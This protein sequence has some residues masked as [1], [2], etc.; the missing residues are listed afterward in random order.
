[1]FPSASWSLIMLSIID[2]S[3]TT[4]NSKTSDTSETSNSSNNTP[5]DGPQPPHVNERILRLREIKR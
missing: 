4:N 5:D 3:N 1:M 2:N